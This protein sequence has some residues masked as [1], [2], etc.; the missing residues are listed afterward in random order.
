[1][2]EMGLHDPFGRICNTRY[3]QKKGQESNGNLTP[4]LDKS[5][6][7]PIP[8]RAGGVQHAVEKLSTRATTLV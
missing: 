5:R 2:S 7:D 4:D 3:G 1:M 8:L 6:I